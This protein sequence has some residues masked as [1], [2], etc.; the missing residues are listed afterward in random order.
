MRATMHLAMRPSAAHAAARNIVVRS[1]EQGSHLV[2]AP[3]DGVQVIMQVWE[4]G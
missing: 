3:K 1:V 4:A 2:T